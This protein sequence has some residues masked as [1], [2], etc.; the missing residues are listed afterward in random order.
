MEDSRQILEAKVQPI[1]D[2]ERGPGSEFDASVHK[3]VFVIARYSR[4]LLCC[5]ESAAD[6][7]NAYGR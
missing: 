1:C 5:G 7:H 4:S 3:N 2:G 6:C